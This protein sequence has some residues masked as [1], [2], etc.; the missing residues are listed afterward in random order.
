MTMAA[1]PGGLETASQA[2]T[3]ASHPIRGPAPAHWLKARRPI[4]HCTLP[5]TTSA[6]TPTSWTYPHRWS[7]AGVVDLG[8]G[9]A[10]EAAPQHGHQLGCGERGP[11]ELEEVAVL[12]HR[13]GAQ[14]LRPP[15]G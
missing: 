10:R 11:P 7:P 1:R 4:N 8:D 5:S 13:H 15:L 3:R 9:H 2:T 12:C 6:S 14:L